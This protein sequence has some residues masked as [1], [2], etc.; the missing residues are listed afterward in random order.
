MQVYK[1]AACDFCHGSTGNGGQAHDDHFGRVIDPGPSLVQSKLSREAMIE[2]VSCGTP[3]GLMP[4]F[5]AAA[6]TPALPCYGKLAADLAPEA[7]PQQPS[8]YA[9]PPGPY[10]ALSR[11]QVEAVV[12]YVQAVY[13]GKG[14]SL[15]NC[16]KYHGAASRACDL[17]R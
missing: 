6:W 3:G 9:V 14:M 17:L 7:R 5:L 12:D 11:T 15:A 1:T 16:I 4:Q 2:A 13:Q 10:R 8:P